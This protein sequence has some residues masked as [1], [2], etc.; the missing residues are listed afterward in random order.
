MSA[1]IKLLPNYFKKI[2]LSLIIITIISVVII[3]VFH[4]DDSVNK[5]ILGTIVIDLLTIFCCMIIFSRDKIEDEMT[6]LI[7]LKEFAGTFIFSV[8]FFILMNIMAIFTDENPKIFS[9]AQ[10]ILTM[11]FSHLFFHYLNIW[12]NKKQNN[13]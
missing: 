10:L 2:G 8:S 6:I 12:K 1:T 11:C 13:E 7:R 5:K 4:F 9:A 3:K